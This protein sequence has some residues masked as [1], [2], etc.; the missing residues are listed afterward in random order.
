[1]A[2]AQIAAGGD[3]AEAELSHKR[4]LLTTSQDE[5]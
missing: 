5:A 1:L 2:H 3:F 4:Q